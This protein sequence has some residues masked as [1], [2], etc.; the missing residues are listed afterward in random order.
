MQYKILVLMPA[1]VNPYFPTIKSD[2]FNLFAAKKPGI[3]PQ[4]FSQ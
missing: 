3:S 1:S 4:A 2:S